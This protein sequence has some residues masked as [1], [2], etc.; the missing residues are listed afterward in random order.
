MRLITGVISFDADFSNLARTRSG[1]DAFAGFRL[2]SSF[3]MTGAVN[4]LPSLIT[5][6]DF[7]YTDKLLVFRWVPIVLLL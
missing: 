7:I 5:H 4:S 1:P 3:S 2:P 6:L